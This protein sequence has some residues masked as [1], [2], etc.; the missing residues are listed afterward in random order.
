MPDE[1]AVQARAQTDPWTVMN[2]AQ[3]LAE[4]GALNLDVPVSNVLK[5]IERHGPPPGALG[6]NVLFGDNYVLVY[7]LKDFDRTAQR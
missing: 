2:L 7:P 6:W 5:V 4:S 3:R 1:K